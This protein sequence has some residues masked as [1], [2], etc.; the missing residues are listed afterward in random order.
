MAFCFIPRC[1]RMP[2]VPPRPPQPVRARVEGG[3]RRHDAR[4]NLPHAA[5]RRNLA[6][7]VSGHWC[8]AEATVVP[9]RV[10]GEGA[11]RTSARS[12][13]AGRLRG[14]HGVRSGS[15]RRSGAGRGSGGSDR[16]RGR[17]PSGDRRRPDGGSRD[18]SSPSMRSGP[19]EISPLPGRHRFHVSRRTRMAHSTSSSKWSGGP[20][21]SS[22]AGAF[23]T[24]AARW[25][26]W[27]S[28]PAGVDATI[29]SHRLLI[30]KDPAGL[31][32]RIREPGRR[33]G[34][35]GQAGRGGQID[36]SRVVSHT[37][38]LAGI[39]EAFDRLQRGEGART[40]VLF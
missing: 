21:R 39:D 16:M 33:T 40:V 1:G 14:A 18:A 27:A 38:D 9:A 12:G 4:R 2:P 36:L 10:G 35:P 5:I 17:W 30:G 19:S 31:V 3:L 34:R 11:R 29:P 8:F 7:A 22:W 32:L 26:W 23:S 13:R 37:T 28:L 6:A 25:W 24:A 15:Q 20:R